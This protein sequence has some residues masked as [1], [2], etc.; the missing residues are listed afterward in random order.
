MKCLSLAFAACL[1]LFA[2]TASA[3]P[4]VPTE[5]QLEWLR[6]NGLATWCLD[7]SDLGL[8][9]V[10]EYG[11]NP[12]VRVICAGMGINPAVPMIAVGYIDEE[13]MMLGVQYVLPDH[14]QDP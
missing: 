3:D 10:C 6:D 14:L 4:V 1:S 8:Y 5:E 13:F 12:N 11:V 7:D 2:A 9:Q